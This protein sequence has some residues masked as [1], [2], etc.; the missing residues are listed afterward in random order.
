MT[1]TAKDTSSADKR[2]PSHSLTALTL[3]ADPVSTLLDR[4]RLVAIADVALRR[5][6]STARG[7]LGLLRACAHEVN[8][9]RP[10]LKQAITDAYAAGDIDAASAQRFVDR[11]ELWS[12]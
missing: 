5:D 1:M 7:E 4:D 8:W 6:R 3:L 12:D 11:F 10:K 2:A 9:L